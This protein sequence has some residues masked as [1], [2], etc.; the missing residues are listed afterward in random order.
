M[1]ASRSQVLQYFKILDISITL[2]G[3]TLLPSHF[4]KI[5]FPHHTFPKYPSHHTFM[6]YP[7]PIPLS[8][9]T[10]I[11]SHFPK[12][13]LL[14]HTFPKYPSYITLSPN[15]PLNLQHTCINTHTLTSVPTYTKDRSTPKI[16]SCTKCAPISGP[17]PNMKEELYF[18]II[19]PHDSSST[20][21]SL[22]GLEPWWFR[23]SSTNTCISM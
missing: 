1:Q 19:I 4:S 22:F 13:P 8:R 7:S 9:I 17:T 18:I 2:F 14:H 3:N 5:P 23:L 20:N 12:M 15:N 10:L 16:P 6:K 11:P 21:P